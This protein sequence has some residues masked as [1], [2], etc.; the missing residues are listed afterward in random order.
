[1]ET[2]HDSA[3]PSSFL[4]SC[5]PSSDQRVTTES[6]EL[7]TRNVAPPSLGSTSSP[8]M[9]RH[10]GRIVVV[11]VPPLSGFLAGAAASGGVSVGLGRTGASGAEAMN[12]G[13][14]VGMVAT[15][16]VLMI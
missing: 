7:A 5:L 4:A 11:G 13:G 12:C 14:K 8:T 2:P 3:G 16:H 1:M 9:P 15:Y 6:S 10:S